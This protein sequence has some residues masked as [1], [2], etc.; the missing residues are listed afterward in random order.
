MS[1]ANKLRIL[2]AQIDEGLRVLQDIAVFYRELRQKELQMLGQSQASA[3]LLAD[4]YISFYT[5]CETIFVRI[6]SFFENSLDPSRWHRELLERMI[7]SIPDLRPC[8]LSPQS[9][10]LLEEFMRFRHFKR[11]YFEFT[12]DW[13]RIAY[14]E[15]RFNEALPLVRQDLTRFLE[16]LKAISAKLIG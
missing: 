16:A 8:V 11:Y 3:I 2:E 9:L 15:D 1:A 5:C 12:Y 4:I 10:R 13:K 6:S 14:L 7:L